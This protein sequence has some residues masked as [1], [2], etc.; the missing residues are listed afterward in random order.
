MKNTI[1]F[2]V[3][4]KQRLYSALFAVILLAGFLLGCPNPAGN[5]EEEPPQPPPSP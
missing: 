5:K 1:K 3:P 4:Q 2:Y